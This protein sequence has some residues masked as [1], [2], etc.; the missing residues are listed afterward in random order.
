MPP[1][2]N[3]KPAPT[4]APVA[5][6]QAPDIPPLLAEIAKNTQ[7]YDAG[8]FAPKSADE[9]W[10]L[11]EDW[12]LSGLLP[13][14]YYPKEG[15]RWAENA[16]T[17]GVRRAVIVMRYGASLGVLPEQAV[18]QIY[19]VEG[20][21]CPSAALMLSMAFASGVLKREDWRIVEASRTKVVI[22]L[23]GASRRGQV[24]RVVTTF[25]DYKHLHNRKNWQAYPEDMLI[26]RAT[27][28]AMRRYFP[29]M[30]AGVYATE[31]R[32]DMRQDRAAGRIEDPVDRIMGMADAPEEPTAPPPAA[33]PAR[34]SEPGDTAEDD[35]GARTMAE[36]LIAD[37]QA[38]ADPNDPRWP[39]LH[40][41]MIE[42]A[43]GP[44]GV[45]VVKERIKLLTNGDGHGQGAI[46]AA[47]AKM[48]AEAV[49]ACQ[50]ALKARKDAA[51]AKAG[52][53]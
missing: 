51:R 50:T 29:D 53:A 37:M 46:V 21:P 3:S 43:P 6:N 28:R 32:V 30:F 4:P 20:Q 40:R 45:E 1:Q 41:R 10:S 39:E 31:E 16:R 44:H 19:I 33:P 34:T 22:E 5:P 27:S 17:Y 15:N 42:L 36:L 18:R 52:G 38:T 7:R 14:A 8:R 47:M 12:Y 24:E 13:E 11:A 48:P 25:D 35:G 26:A 49:E 23:F 9:L 2:L